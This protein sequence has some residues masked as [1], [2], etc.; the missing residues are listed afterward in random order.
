MGHRA[1]VAYRRPD[2]RYDL[3]YSHWGGDEL[4]L[5]ER[6][7]VETPLAGG[8]VD[9]TVLEPRVSVAELLER[10][11]DPRTYET[12]YL[13]STAFSVEAEWVCWL[14]WDADRTGREPDDGPL[15]SEARGAIVPVERS[16][17]V[18]RLR[19]WLRA[20]K[21]AL[22]DLVAV[23]ALSTETAQQYLQAR[24]R[25]THSGRCYTYRGVRMG[26]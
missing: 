26:T 12:L 24:V 5:L 11:L 2:G 7:D 14:G 1:I 21:A 17:E 19:T 16:T 8:L 13:V 4:S 23:G 15:R 25:S 9:P 10:V 20:T 6:I 22:T 18:V 3:R